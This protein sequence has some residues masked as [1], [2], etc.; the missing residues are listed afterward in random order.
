LFVFAHAQSVG[1]TH[2][3]SQATPFNLI[4]NRMEVVMQC[5]IVVYHQFIQL[6]ISQNGLEEVPGI[7]AR[8]GK[9]VAI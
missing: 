5:S 2:T 1:I 4:D 6:A 9:S 7:P 3:I 8:S